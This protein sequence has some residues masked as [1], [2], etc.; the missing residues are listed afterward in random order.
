MT[1]IGVIAAAT[2]RECTRRR[3]FG[4]II[5]LTGLFLALYTL[6]TV[7]A[8]HHLGKPAPG[9]NVDITVLA[10]ATLLGLAM[11]AT[12]FL[13][14]VVAVFLTF[15]VLRGDAEQ[16]LLQP[17]VVRPPGR[18]VFLAGR[19]GAAAL[20]SAVYAATVYAAAVVI[21]GLV[22]GWWPDEVVLPGV[23][24]AA[25][26]AVVTAIS[27]AGSVYLSTIANGIAVLM[28]FGAGLVGG[29]LGQIGDSIHS[30]TLSSIGTVTSWAL[31]FAALYQSGLHALTSETSGLTGVIVHLG[32][33]GGA[34]PTG[35]LLAPW[36][37][38]YILVVVSLAGAAFARRDL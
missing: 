30:D 19:F 6:G 27:L 8:F 22:G 10:G 3:V 5:V 24:L 11:F 32:P 15:N 33:L 34:Q 14:T 4:V 13:S 20:V 9:D 29:L 31:P 26:A 17:M 35:P 18:V 28:L 38:G 25:G 7:T 1:G 2:L 23:E 37:L 36:V 21:T 12:L 16:G